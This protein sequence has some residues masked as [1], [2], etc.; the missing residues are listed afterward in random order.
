V[1]TCCITATVAVPAGIEAAE[2]AE[3]P[4]GLPKRLERVSR[5][6]ARHGAVIHGLP[7]ILAP[8]EPVQ[9]LRDAFPRHDFA[10]VAVR[11]PAGAFEEAFERGQPT[12]E[13]VVDG[14]SFQMQE[15]VSVVALDS[16]D[17]SEPLQLGADRDTWLETNSQSAIMAKFST[18]HEGDFRW[19]TQAVRTPTLHGNSYP[20]DETTRKALWW[21]VKGLS[22]PWVIDRFLFFWTALDLVS[23]VDSRYSV[24]EPTKTPCGHEVPT[25][26]TCGKDTNRPRGGGVRMR[27][28]PRSARRC[29]RRS[30]V[31]VEPPTGVAWPGCVHQE[32]DGSH[33]PG[34]QHASGGRARDDQDR[35]R[36]AARRGAVHGLAG[37]SRHRASVPR[38]TPAH[39]PI[40]RRYSGRAPCAAG[41]E[42]LMRMSVMLGAFGR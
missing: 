3:E 33:G 20:S 31:N 4:G 17:V 37:R 13:A 21:Y 8:Y 41:T 7:V 10:E 36:R 16:L 28:V 23:G 26:P 27:P 32:R 15:V 12:L 19:I 2:P 18:V 14:L 1:E 34:D 22:V 11:V 30:K 6:P 9:Q 24:V 42:F 38:R 40:R 5:V 35:S 29:G 25:C 39:Q